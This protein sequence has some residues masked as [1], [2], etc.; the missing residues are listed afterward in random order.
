[1]DGVRQPL[2]P[3]EAP[4]GKHQK[5]HY[6]QINT[7]GYRGAGSGDKKSQTKAEPGSKAWEELRQQRGNYSGV[8]LSSI[9]MW[10]D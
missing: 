6:E 9:S 8:V 5:I 1:M 7:T 3:I 10:V 4:A 2:D